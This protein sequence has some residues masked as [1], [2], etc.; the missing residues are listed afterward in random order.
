MLV[1]FYHLSSIGPERVLAQIG[2]KLLGNGERLL[3]VADSERLAILDVQLWTHPP[4]SFLPHGLSGAP[5][6]EAQPVLLSPVAQ[7]LNGAANI[8][9]ADGRW[10]EEALGF[11]RV[12]YLFDESRIDEARAAWRRLRSNPDAEC[13]YWKRSGEG[14]WV[15]GP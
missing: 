4:G 14:Q 6:A 8:A 15:K 10:N 9:L 2:E 11:A 7:A 3:V 1:D 13:R 12:F 5:R